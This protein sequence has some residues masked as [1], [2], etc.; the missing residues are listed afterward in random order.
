[1]ADDVTTALEEIRARNERHIQTMRLTD[2]TVRRDPTGDVRRL[3]AA[4]WAALDLHMA[5]VADGPDPVRVC[6]YCSMA[7]PCAEYRA[8]QAALA[9]AE[10][11]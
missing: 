10:A 11:S 7:W 2:A 1:M 9:Q 4:L 5:D 6:T 8:I 3:L